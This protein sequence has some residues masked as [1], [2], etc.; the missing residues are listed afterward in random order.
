MKELLEPFIHSLVIILKTHTHTHTRIIVIV[1]IMILIRVVLLNY[2]MQ[3]TKCGDEKK[4][5][6]KGGQ[7]KT[8]TKNTT[9]SP[10]ENIDA[11][12]S[13]KCCTWFILRFC[14]TEFVVVV[15]VVVV[16]GSFV[17]LV[18]AETKRSVDYSSN[19]LHSLVSLR[20]FLHA[21]SVGEITYTNVTHLTFFSPLL[22]ADHILFH[23][24]IFC[25]SANIVKDGN[26]EKA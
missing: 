3:V 19:Y 14:P 11:T 16:G 24:D 2:C 5:K 23:F 21:N 1:I 18:V 26:R 20:T 17:W 10:A 4:R 22:I 7:K 8:K 25:E 6:R 15:V 12:K 13:Q 9:N